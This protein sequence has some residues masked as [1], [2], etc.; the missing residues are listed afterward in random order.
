[1]V[2]LHKKFHMSI[3]NGSLVISITNKLEAKENV[4]VATMLIF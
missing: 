2:F 1:M 3:S 4:H